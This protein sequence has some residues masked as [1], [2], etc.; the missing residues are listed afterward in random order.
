MRHI[1]GKISLRATDDCLASTIS[2]LIEACIEEK[3]RLVEGLYL[4][5]MAVKPFYNQL[6]KTGKAALG[7]M[8]PNYSV[9]HDDKGIPQWEPG[10]TIDLTGGVREISFKALLQKAAVDPIE[11][12]KGV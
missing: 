1:S 5:I 12:V 6:K 9:M 4:R 3:T 10:Y 11:V 2:N 8:Y 7:G